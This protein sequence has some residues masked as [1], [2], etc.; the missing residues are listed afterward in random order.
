MSLIFSN[1]LLT[2]KVYGT[3]WDAC[4]WHCEPSECDIYYCQSELGGNWD[5]DACMCTDYTPI[6]IDL[7]RDGL[8]LTNAEDGVTF[9]IRGDQRPV[10]TSWTQ[11]DAQDAFLVLDRDHNGTIDNGSELFGNLTPQPQRASKSRANKKA[12]PNGFL[13]LSAFDAPANG[14]NGD[15]LISEEDAIYASLRLWIDTNHD[16]ISQPTEL[17][18]LADEGVRAISLHYVVGKES[19]QC[20]NVFR[21]RSH[22]VMD[23]DLLERGSQERNVID[24]LLQ[25]TAAPVI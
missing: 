17:T 12:A 9:D 18:S 23:G 19:D 20:G 2:A 22:A 3:A 16:G 25:V 21:Y 10:R 5:W 4:E 24:V 13:A 8:A 7:D 1:W 15:K 14:G 11:P 6:A